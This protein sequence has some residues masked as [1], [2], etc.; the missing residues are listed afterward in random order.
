MM[1]P[2]SSADFDPEFP[3]AGGRGSAESAKSAEFAGAAEP[4]SQQRNLDLEI[5]LGLD[6]SL[7]GLSR[8]GGVLNRVPLIRTGL[9]A[10]A[11]AAYFASVTDASGGVFLAVTFGGFLVIAIGQV[12]ND[13]VEDA[14]RMCR[15]VL[16]VAVAIGV[17][18]FVGSLIKPHLSANRAA[19]LSEFSTAN[20]PPSTTGSRHW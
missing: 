3:D 8:Q 10:F 18:I 17:V 15:G 16:I 12:A 20:F 2:S 11:V 1:A 4:M 6:P 13:M 9:V 7:R 14:R 19:P 5:M